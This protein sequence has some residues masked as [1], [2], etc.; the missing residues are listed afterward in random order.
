MTR[1]DLH[2]SINPAQ[3]R[4][5]VVEIVQR[6]K[7]GLPGYR[8]LGAPPAAAAALE[9]A[10]EGLNRG[11]FFL[12]RNQ[13]AEAL[14]RADIVIGLAPR[15]NRLLEDGW[16]LRG[17]VCLQK[18]DIQSA[19]QAFQQ[20]ML[21]NPAHIAA[22]IGM[23]ETFKKA[24]Q[25]ERAIPI[26]VETIPLVQEAQKRT[27]LRLLLA[28]TYLT[29]GKPEAARR[30]LFTV[31][32][33]RGLSISEKMRAA[34]TMLVPDSMLMW[35]LLLFVTSIVGSFAIDANLMAGL[36]SLVVGVIVYAALQWWR[37]PAH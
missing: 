4:R 25:H 13:L 14:L 21:L 15:E 27:R 19:R 23:T 17:E 24:H 32:T 5:E 16:T 31:E 36:T 6:R 10:E 7:R 18:G 26:Y 20:A 12:E 34:F 29:V 30:V 35:F 11:R 8:G 37:T 2:E 1:N 33:T 22:R 3:L 9:K 28:Q